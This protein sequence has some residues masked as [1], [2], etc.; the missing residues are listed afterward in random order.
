MNTGVSLRR[1][2]EIAVRL[3]AGRAVEEFQPV[4]L[5]QMSARLCLRQSGLLCACGSSG[6]MKGLAPELCEVEAC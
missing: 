4:S 3:Q 1:E 2:T 6:R 5:G